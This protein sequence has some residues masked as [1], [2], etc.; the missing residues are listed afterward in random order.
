MNTTTSNDILPNVRHSITTRSHN[1]LT[2]NP[3]I[4]TREAT[5]KAAWEHLCQARN[6]GWTQNAQDALIHSYLI[7]GTHIAAEAIRATHH[8]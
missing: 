1:Q 5:K 6:A 2:T 4:T 3:T 7:I 8:N